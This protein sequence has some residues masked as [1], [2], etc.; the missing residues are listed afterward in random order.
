MTALMFAAPDIALIA[1]IGALYAL[2][3]RNRRQ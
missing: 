3:R 1:C 2:Y